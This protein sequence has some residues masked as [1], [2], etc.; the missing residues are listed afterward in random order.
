MIGGVN[1]SFGGSN[2]PAAQAVLMSI[3]ALG[4]AENKRHSKALFE[5]V[6]QAI[7]VPPTR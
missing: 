6:E 7:G 3:G 5:A 4:V 1:M 2:E